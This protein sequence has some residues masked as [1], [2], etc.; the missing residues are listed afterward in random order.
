MLHA[1]THHPI[2]YK[3][4]VLSFFYPFNQSVVPFAQVLFALSS[5]A[6]LFNRSAVRI[7]SFLFL[8]Y[9]VETGVVFNV[10]LVT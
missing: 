9:L 1:S 10:Y 6:S 3:D 5:L 4:H 8:M 2:F 7:L